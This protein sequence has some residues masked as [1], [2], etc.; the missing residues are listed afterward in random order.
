MLNILITGYNGFIGTHLVKS[1][2]S[3]KH[4]VIGLSDNE[5]KNSNVIRIK[6]DIRS[7]T[8]REIRYKIDAIIHLAALSD[9]QY[10]QNNPTECFETNV[11]GTQKMLE[12]ARQK[13]SKFVY[14]STNH[15]YG[16]PKNLP[17]NEKHPTN[18]LSI[19]AASKLGGEICCQAYAKIYGMDITILRLYSVYGPKSPGHL[20]IA[21][22]L[23]QLKT[24]RIIKLGNMYPKRDFVYVTDVVNAIKLVLE[25]NSGF[26]VYNVGSEKS[27]SISEI[28]KIIKNITG[29]KF[30]VKSTA[31]LSR[32]TEVDN[33]VSDSSKI[34][35]LG[36][37][38]TVPLETGLKIT[39]S[40]N[41]YE[42]PTKK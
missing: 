17:I 20:V 41:P 36:W 33:I 30:I 3:E 15:V 8:A 5:N 32:K 6:K 16:I 14:V 28:C 38:V 27:H 2:Q 1:L 10:C 31:S 4:K 35:K 23:D 34:K 24:K 19:Y 9:V 42:T 40:E 39:I 13:N 37:K 29:K 26:N 11:I 22:I 25:K 18:P 21:R 7:V 12:L